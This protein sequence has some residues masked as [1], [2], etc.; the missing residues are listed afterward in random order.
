MKTIKSILKTIILK[1]F[2]DIFCNKSN[3]TTL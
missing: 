1:N 2:Q 3:N